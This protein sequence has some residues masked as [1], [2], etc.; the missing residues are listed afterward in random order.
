MAEPELR[1]IDSRTVYKNRWMTVREDRVRRANGDDGLYG[2]VEKP[3]FSLIVP[4][5]GE[6]FHLVQQY[7]YPVGGRYWEFPQGSKEL[8]PDT[9]PE[10]VAAEE[11]AEE[12]GLT[13]NS[14]VHL[15]RLFQAYGYSNQAVN[16]YLATEL[17][18]G[19]ASPEVEE[20]GL[21]TQS[22]TRAQFDAMLKD[23]RM[24]DLA[25]VAALQ[26]FDRHMS[27]SA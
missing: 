5:D 27:T 13:A 16:V 6:K 24:A 21:I 14:I 18:P 8:E 15:G 11:L 22:F 4:F 3:D 19:E 23:G 12:T 25:S 26:L 20:E 1:R 17:T 10:Q 9:A 2:V 7:R